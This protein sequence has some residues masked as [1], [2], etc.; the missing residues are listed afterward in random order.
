MSTLKL[1][2]TL[3]PV[4][5]KNTRRDSLLIWLPL[6]P[7][8]MALL[9]RIGVPIAADWLQT[10]FDFVLRDYYPLLM[11]L[12]LVQAP[13]LIGMIVGLLLLDE[14]DDGVLD[15]LRVT[16]VPLR[17][18]LTYRAAGPMALGFVLTLIGYPLA[19][20]TPLP[21][22]QVAALA[23][24][25]CLMAPQLALFLA[26]FAENKVAGLALVK[27]INGVMM[28]P[29]AAYFVDGPLQYGAGVLPTFWLLKAFWLAAD[30]V[31][32]WGAL[33]MALLTNALLVGWLLRR[34]ERV[35]AR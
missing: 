12:F 9:F 6:A 3:G 5:W 35:V 29:L 30:G 2:R 23:L 4:D 31:A 24:V 21:I 20:L 28:L 8:L 17:A 26:T 7:L 32:F 15:A 34:F 33:L 14:R 13:A 10:E 19:G 22:L 16:P 27:L 11:S 1:F 18:Y 25:G